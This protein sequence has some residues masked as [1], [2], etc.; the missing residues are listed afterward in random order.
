MC[1]FIVRSIMQSD[2]AKTNDCFLS[3]ESQYDDHK[4]KNTNFDL[5]FL[6]GLGCLCITVALIILSQVSSIH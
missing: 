3:K 1:I 4:K 5:Y 6:I 2:P